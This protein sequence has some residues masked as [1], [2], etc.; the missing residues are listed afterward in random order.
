MQIE[1]IQS[2]VVFS[3]ASNK[4]KPL[5]DIAAIINEGCIFTKGVFDILHYGHLSLFSF[6]DRLKMECKLKVVVGVTSDRVVKFKK[7]QS[8]PINPQTERTLQ[9]A[10]LSAVDFVYIHDEVDYIDAISTLKPAIY[11]KGMDTVGDQNEYQLL[12]Q[13]NPEF[14]SLKANAKII[15]YNDDSS[16]STSIVIGRIKNDS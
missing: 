6:L 7:G 11:V 12:L 16:I 2:S 1:N 14:A 10:F 3:S 15:V 5:N 9:I 8:R 4:I 13:K